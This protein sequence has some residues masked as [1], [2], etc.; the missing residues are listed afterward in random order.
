MD[1]PEE[2]NDLEKAGQHFI[3]GWPHFCKCIDFNAT[4]LDAEAIRFFNE[5]PGEL[6]A[7]LDKNQKGKNHER[8]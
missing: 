4:N 7:A 1:L 8:N 5:V 6:K 3:E 2:I